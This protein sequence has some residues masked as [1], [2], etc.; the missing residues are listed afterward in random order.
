MFSSG[1]SL[2]L[3]ILLG[4]SVFFARG[5]GFSTDVIGTVKDSVTGSPISNAVVKIVE[6]GD[7]TMTDGLGNYFIPN[8]PSGRYTFLVGL[9]NYRPFIGGSIVVGACC[10]GL[11]GNVDSDPGDAVDIGDLVYMV[12]Y[13]FAGG[14]SPLCQEEADV[15]GDISVD[16]GD[17][18]Y[19]VEYSF[20][21]GPAPN[22]CP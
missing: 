20:G 19:L 8:L 6:T 12:E 22:A 18:V 10:V 21:T 15:N 4:L 13:S 2:R 17:L 3:F 5:I 9:A 1:F 16:I 14:P 7:S 11:R